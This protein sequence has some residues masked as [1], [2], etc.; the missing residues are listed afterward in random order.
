[1][2][3]VEGTSTRQPFAEKI[4]GQVHH[5]I[6]SDGALETLLKPPHPG[7]QYLRGVDY[8][9]GNLAHW[10]TEESVEASWA[11]GHDEVPESA[12][13][14]RVGKARVCGRSIPTGGVAII[15]P[16]W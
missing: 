16:V 11:E 1:L 6:Y 4:L 13:P 12:L 15:S 14:Q 5:S 9:I 8:A 7:S 3:R 2:N 10:N